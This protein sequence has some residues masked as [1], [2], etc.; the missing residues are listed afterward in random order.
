MSEQKIDERAHGRYWGRNYVHP[1]PDCGV[2]PFNVDDCGHF[3]NP[4]CPYFGIGREKYERNL[5]GIITEF[6]CPP[7]P[8]RAFDWRA[9]YDGEQES[10][11]CGY[12][13]TKQKAIDDL[14]ALVD[15]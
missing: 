9:F 3:G 4:E 1:C 2:A 12:G 8:T 14:E 6:V 10:G 7:I 13:E 11:C 5:R 15:E